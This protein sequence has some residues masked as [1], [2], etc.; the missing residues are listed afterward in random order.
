MHPGI[1]VQKS[2]RILHLTND[3]RGVVLIELV[4]SCLI[5]VIFFFA[6]IETWS[7]IRDKVQLQRV[8]R[9][10]AREAALVGSISAG[11]QIGR[12][13]AQQY[14]G[15]NASRVQIHLQEYIQPQ[16]SL[17]VGTA[18]YQRI[19]FGQLSRDLFG[20]EVMLSARAVFGW[21][22]LIENYE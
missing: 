14:Y 19:I 17:V 11:E 10:A 21:K 18:T 22:D 20:M 15:P 12:D 2:R 9:D 1:Q 16:S 5:L 6:A 7:I 3:K 13:R 8:V 4:I